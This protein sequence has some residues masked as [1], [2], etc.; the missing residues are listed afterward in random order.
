MDADSNRA[1]PQSLIKTPPEGSGNR[2]KM[3]KRQITKDVYRAEM[4]KEA[5]RQLAFMNKCRMHKRGNGVVN[6][7]FYTKFQ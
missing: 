2:K 6:Q 5:R 4:A 7:P 1:L 3:Y